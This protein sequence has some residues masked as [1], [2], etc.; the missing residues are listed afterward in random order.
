[1]TESD[2]GTIHSQA[3]QARERGDFTEALKLTEDAFAAYN[4]EGNGA[5]AAEVLASKTLTLRHLY[6]QTGDISYLDQAKEEARRSVQ[7]ATASGVGGATILPR[8]NL[9]KVLE[10]SGELEEATGVMEG[11]VDDMMKNPP[12]ELKRPSVKAEME[13]RLATFEYRGGDKSALERAEKSLS[14]LEAADEPDEY[15]RDVWV[16]GGHM[17]IA[18]M[19]VEDDPAKAKEH[20]EKARAIID[21]NPKLTLRRAQFEKLSQSF[22]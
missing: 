21:G 2:A 9:A 12:E 17:K 6:E 13:V 15:A 16:S 5:K 10:T 7:V 4:S 1:M 20:L 22:S 8:Y 11:V 3:E 19:L 18:A 14:D